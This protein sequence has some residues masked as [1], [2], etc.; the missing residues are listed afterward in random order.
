MELEDFD[1]W[2]TTVQTE[3]AEAGVTLQD[4]DARCFASAHAAGRCAYDVAREYVEDLLCSE[5][6]T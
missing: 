3:A 5:T 1:V 4:R 2:W 6:W